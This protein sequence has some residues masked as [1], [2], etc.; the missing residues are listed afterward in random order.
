VA[1]LQG[2]LGNND[3]PAKF[4][5]MRLGLRSVEQCLQP[6][7]R[8]LGVLIPSR[9]VCGLLV[10][11]VHWLILGVL[12]QNLKDP[13][14]SPQVPRSS[15][16]VRWINP[17]IKELRIESTEL[18]SSSASGIRKKYSENSTTPSIV[19]SPN[20]ND[21]KKQID[22]ETNI[23]S[24]TSVGWNPRQYR[25]SQ[26]VDTRSVPAIEWIINHGAAP[27]N[28]FAMLI[29]TVWVSAEGEIDHFQ[30]EDQQPGGDWVAEA[31]SGFQ[32]TVMEPATL[33][34]VPVASTMTI[35]IS[36]DNTNNEPG[37]N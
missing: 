2:A 23:E 6:F 16:Q 7:A 33:A 29:V 25:S 15:F 22:I 4:A 3:Q 36:L 5:F 11:V 26:E 1:T 19:E 34:G 27:K 30:I 12:I 28:S 18:T 17:A 14:I 10:A 31:L 35:E 24:K 21:S 8:Q 13:A 20:T 37:I 32:T 9:L